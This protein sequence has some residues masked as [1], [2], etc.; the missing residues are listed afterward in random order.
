MTCLLFSLRCLPVLAASHLNTYKACALSHLQAA[1][2]DTTD[3]FSL[4]QGVS[5]LVEE[6][7]TIFTFSTVDNEEEPH[8]SV[9]SIDWLILQP[10]IIQAVVQGLRLLWKSSLK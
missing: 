9:E 4:V 3:L 7:N 1:A 8:S 5:L 2:T 10:V 6:R